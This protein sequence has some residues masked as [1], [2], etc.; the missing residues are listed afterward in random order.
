MQAAYRGFI[1]AFLIFLTGCAAT[2]QQPTE[3]VAPLDL[4]GK[5]GVLAVVVT[6]SEEI[7]ATSNWQRLDAE[8]RRALSAAARN[9]GLQF[10]YLET[11]AEE[12]PQGTVLAQITVNDYRYVSPGARFA[13]GI[14]TGN[15]HIDTSVA[16][17]EFPGP[18][19]IGTRSYST[20]SSALQ[21]V[22]SPMIDRQLDAISAEIVR[23]VNGQ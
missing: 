2:V 8:W 9:A 22:M 17:Y 16:F 14:M 6:G 10:L 11:P 15:A 13:V 21:G 5:P 20:S 3:D 12:Q 23:A 4:S 7:L 19:T 18:R 1:V